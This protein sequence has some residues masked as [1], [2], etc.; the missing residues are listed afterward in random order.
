MRTRGWGGDVPASDDDAIARILTAARSAIE[1]FGER[2]TIADVARVLGVTRQTIYHYFANI[3]Q[4]MAAVG[5]EASTSFI[6]GI[7]ASLRGITDPADA[8]VEGIA[9]ALER[10]PGDPLVGLMVR[11]QRATALAEIVLRENSNARIQGRA[12]LI[13]L[14]IDWSAL[15]PGAVDNVLHISLRTLQ[16]LIITPP[17]DSTELRE[18]LRLWIDPAI[19]AMQSEASP[20]AP[21]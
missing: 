6:E 16:S 1:Q 4:L 7:Q 21:S 17:A 12:M 10:L 14:D 8:V 18:L 2:T 20:T 3:D 9:L 11:A 15:P 13:G 19:R 5:A